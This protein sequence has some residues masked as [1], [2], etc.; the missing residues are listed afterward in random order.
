MPT[1]NICDQL[2]VIINNL[3]CLF[4]KLIKLRDDQFIMFDQTLP[5]RRGGGW[6]GGEFEIFVSIWHY[7]GLGSEWYSSVS[8]QLI[9]CICWVPSPTSL[10][11]ITR[12]LPSCSFGLPQ[13]HQVWSIWRM[14]TREWEEHLYQVLF[15]IFRN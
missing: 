13:L 11:M 6:W 12:K 10:L 1:F 15:Q 5:G 9:D 7:M 3:D 2:V 4:T 8:S 14:L